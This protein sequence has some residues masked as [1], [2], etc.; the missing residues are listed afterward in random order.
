[1]THLATFIWILKKDQD[2]LMHH[3][4]DY[5]IAWEMNHWW[6]KFPDYFFA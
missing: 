1:M 6:D 2:M 5:R 4:Y 3:L